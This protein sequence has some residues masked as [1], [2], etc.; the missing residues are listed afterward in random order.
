MSQIDSKPKP[1]A[2]KELND[3]T[4][5][6]KPNQTINDI[7]SLTPEETIQSWIDDGY[8]DDK[9]PLELD[10]KENLKV[11]YVTKEGMLRKGGLLKSVVNENGLQ[12]LTMMN[13]FANAKWSVQVEN[14]DQIFYKK[15][16]PKKK[17][18]PKAPEIVNKISEFQKIYDTRNANNLY[19]LIK[20]NHPECKIS[21]ESVRIFMKSNLQPQ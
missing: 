20:D 2:F 8:K 7:I 21:R 1:R 9:N 19:K 18:D 13:P 14:I 15:V 5:Y 16:T 17:K 12:F 10:P 4:E 11:R 6:V 3:W